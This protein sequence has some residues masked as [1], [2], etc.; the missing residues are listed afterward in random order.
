MDSSGQ[1]LVMLKAPELGRV[2]TRLA[3]SIGAEKALFV[4]QHLL[5]IALNALAPIA[6]QVQLWYTGSVNHLPAQ[7]KAFSLHQQVISDLGYRMAKAFEDSFT[8]YPGQPAIIIGTDCPALFDGNHIYEALHALSSYDMVIG[9]AED[10]GYYLLG[11]RQLH[12]TLFEGIEWSTAGVF[13]QTIAAATEA[14]LSVCE[15]PTLGDIDTIDDL[16]SS[17]WY[18]LLDKEL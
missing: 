1:I 5:A 16:E 15:L 10:G 11:M 13:A 9:P 17:H 4:Y 12:N 14:G 3:A 6:N 2:K 18:Y 8:A 7:V